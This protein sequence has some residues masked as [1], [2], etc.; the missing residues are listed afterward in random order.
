MQGHR[1][2]RGRVGMWYV[3]YML[4][5]Y[6]VNFIMLKMYIKIERLD[7]RQRLRRC[8]ADY[9]RPPRRRNRCRCKYSAT[10]LAG[11]D[12]A[13]MVNVHFTDLQK[14]HNGG[15]F[16]VYGV[17]LHLKIQIGREQGAY[18]FHSHATLHFTYP[19]NPFQ[20]FP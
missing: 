11:R 3:Y 5:M 10:A 1:R 7:P 4:F 14:P 19:P 9:S 2:H 8:R 16:L 17:Y 13:K 12:A 6:S 18:L 20:K 15:A